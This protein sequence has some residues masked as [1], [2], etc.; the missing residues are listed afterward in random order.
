MFI[1]GR[2]GVAHLWL[3]DPLIQTLEIFRRLD[4]AG[5]RVVAAHRGEIQVRAEP[6][7]AVEL[8]LSRLWEP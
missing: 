8:D 3:I 4:D 5:W 6:F 2:E 1:Y 7:D